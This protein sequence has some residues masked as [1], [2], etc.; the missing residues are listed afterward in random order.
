MRYLL[1][2]CFMLTGCINHAVE[3]YY[4]EEG[5]LQTS[6]CYAGRSGELY[7]EPIGLPTY[8]ID[9]YAIDYV[10]FHTYAPIHYLS[11][12][13]RRSADVDGFV[14][15]NREAKTARIYHVYGDVAVIRH[16]KYH[17]SHGDFHL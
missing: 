3:C 12:K 9:E 1:S 8:D 4:D 13:G 10:A 11:G 2:L 15:I 5:D 17:I 14:H 6:F 16:E 7:P